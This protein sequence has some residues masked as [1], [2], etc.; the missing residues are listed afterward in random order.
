MLG[1]ACGIWGAQL[2]GGGTLFRLSS[3]L[4]GA[5]IFWW[6][7]ELPGFGRLGLSGVPAGFLG[8]GGPPLPPGPT[9]ESLVGL[10]D[11]QLRGRVSLHLCTYLC[12]TNSGFGAGIYLPAALPGPTSLGP[13]SLSALQLLGTCL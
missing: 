1:L 10:F 12:C 13:G 11:R 9:E 7:P 6:I 5:I 8:Q 4:A 3:V 2:L